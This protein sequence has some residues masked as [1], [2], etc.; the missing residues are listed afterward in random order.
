MGT[1]V[2]SCISWGRVVIAAVL[3]EVMVM[4]VLTV[5][6]LGY[7]FVIAPGHP[8]SDYTTFNDAASYYVAPLT[9]GVAALLGALWA[10]RTVSARFALH[11]ALVGLTAVLLT[12]GF[13]FFT[14]P[15]NRLMYGVSFLLRVIGGWTGGM[16]AQRMRTRRSTPQFRLADQ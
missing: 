2:T 9:A 8:A 7:R 13:V 10:C 1:Q 4:A 14:K 5:V 6:I 15:E 12:G 3:S 16:I 11:G